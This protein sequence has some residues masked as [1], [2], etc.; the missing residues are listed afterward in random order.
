MNNYHFNNS[1]W[2][3]F[4]DLDTSSDPVPRGDRDYVKY[5]CDNTA[6][7]NRSLNLHSDKY[8]DLR[9]DDVGDLNND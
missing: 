4:F 3:V 5:D 6:P 9:L 7:R 2:R 1:Q 8:I